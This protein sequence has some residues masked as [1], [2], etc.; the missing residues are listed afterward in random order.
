MHLFFQIN[1]FI[2]EFWHGWLHCNHNYSVLCLHFVS[3]LVKYNDSEGNF[4]IK[5]K[6]YFPFIIF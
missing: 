4:H 6:L 3:P 2:F 1:M 5:Y